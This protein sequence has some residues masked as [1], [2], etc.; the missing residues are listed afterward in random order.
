MVTQAWF[1]G[2]LLREKIASKVN[3]LSGTS[4]SWQF[5]DTGVAVKLK[6]PINSSPGG[7]CPGH[8]RQRNTA[9]KM[10]RD[11]MPRAYLRPSQWIA[12]ARKELLARNTWPTSTCAG[13][14]PRICGSSWAITRDAASD[15]GSASKAKQTAWSKPSIGSGFASRNPRSPR[16]SAKAQR[17]P[18]SA[19]RKQLRAAAPSTNS[20]ELS[21]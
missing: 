5:E 3:P 8:A 7:F 18:S 6:V 21:R 12:N 17:N 11:L 10:N 1:P 2:F 15:E 9:T 20:F 4:A 14:E 13:F 19:A 16:A